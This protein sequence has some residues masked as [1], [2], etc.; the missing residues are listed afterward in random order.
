MPKHAGAG[1]PAV[2]LQTDESLRAERERADRALAERQQAIHNEADSVIAVAR[3]HADAVLG[4]A[5]EK[6]DELLAADSGTPLAAG[7]ALEDQRVAEDAAVRDERQTADESLRVEREDT[8]RTLRT[9]IPLERE[10]T[11]RYLLTERAVWDDALGN[12]DDFLGIVS[13]D[14]RGLLGGI[15]NA[16]AILSR[17][18]S[19][20]P[21]GRHAVAQADRIQRYAARMNRLICDLVDVA[22]IEAGKLAVVPALSDATILLE[23]AAETFAAT[24]VTKNIVLDVQLAA[25]PLPATFDHARI[26]QVMTNLVSNAVKFT[27]VGGRIVVRGERRGGGLR[28]SVSDSGPGIPEHLL[29]KVFERFWQ[30]DASQR[31]SLGLGLYISRCIV[32]AHRGRVWAESSAA[33]GTTVY[34]TLPGPEDFAP[35]TAGAPIRGLTDDA[36]RSRTA[37]GS[38][39]P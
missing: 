31:W 36:R 2:R 5:R 26:L 20:T 28:L 37:R 39:Q 16:A 1:N 14:L 38:Q 18:A 10:K 17:G 6:A 30:A 35:R 3:E 7:S 27:P 25:R 34:L 23:E 19:D 9:L 4:A 32:E 24:A 21:D 13:H 12:R 11:D 33:T 8:T 29:E 15:V 22:S